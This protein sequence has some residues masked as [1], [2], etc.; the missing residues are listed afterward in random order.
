MGRFLTAL[1]LSLALVG[2]AAAQADMQADP[3]PEL[4][5]CTADGRPRAYCAADSGA[6]LVLYNL[7]TAAMDRL[8]EEGGGA[9]L[10]LSR[11]PGDEGYGSRLEVIYL[12]EVGFPEDNL[13][14][15]PW[16]FVRR[17]ISTVDIGHLANDA[18]KPQEA[19]DRAR[20]L[21]FADFDSALAGGRIDDLFPNFR[22]VAATLPLVIEEASPDSCPGVRKKLN[23][24]EPLLSQS[25]DIY[26]VGLDHPM[27]PINTFDGL[28]RTLQV[29]GMIGGSVGT[30]TFE[31]GEEHPLSQWQDELF[32]L[33]KPCWRPA[34]SVN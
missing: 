2:S 6:Y 5:S 34:V 17:S 1:A 9:G 4:Q 22:A 29:R 25:V 12:T 15:R 19:D 26:G 3:G 31:M 32:E 21:G 14:A 33:L 7:W 30:I 20:A 18:W 11:D 8:R 23:E 13:S 27:R 16:V 10:L 28:V 24:L